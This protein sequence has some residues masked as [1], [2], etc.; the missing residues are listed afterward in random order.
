MS[1]IGI[2]SCRDLVLRSRGPHLAKLQIETSTL[3]LNFATS[4]TALALGSAQAVA[5]FSYCPHHSVMGTS[6]IR[7]GADIRRG[8]INVRN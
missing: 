2:K 1:Y 6:A 5:H 3:P 4:G 8:M 7:T